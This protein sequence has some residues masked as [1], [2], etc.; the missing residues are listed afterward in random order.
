MT[1]SVQY[2]LLAKSIL[3]NV[4]IVQIRA[5][6]SL[7]EELAPSTSRSDNSSLLSDL[8]APSVKLVDRQLPTLLEDLRPATQPAFPFPLQSV[9]SLLEELLS[10]PRLLFILPLMALPK[11][12]EAQLHMSLLLLL[13]PSPPMLYRQLELLLVYSSLPAERLSLSQ[14][15]EVS[16][17]P[18]TFRQTP[19]EELP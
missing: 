11:A 5:T 10:S 9:L 18:I 8:Q 3:L 12:S 14:H 7:P 16:H 2:L 13:T 6:T 4:P 17:R 19:E 15:L 1:R